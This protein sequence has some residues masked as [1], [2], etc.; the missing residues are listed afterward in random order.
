MQA[1]C[2]CT[3]TVNVLNSEEDK[4]NIFVRNAEGEILNKSPGLVCDP[5]SSQWMAVSKPLWQKKWTDYF[6]ESKK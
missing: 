2:P 5:M 6:W 1:F 4:D 3:T